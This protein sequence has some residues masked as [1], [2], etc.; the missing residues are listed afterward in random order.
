MNASVVS[1]PTAAHLVY[2]AQCRAIA[3]EMMPY[4][5]SIL[6]RLDVWNAPGLGT[7]AVDRRWRP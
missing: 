7:Y 4:L 3:L 1:R 2:L 6:L 5:S